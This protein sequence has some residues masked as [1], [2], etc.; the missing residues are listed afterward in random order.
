MDDDDG[1][2]WV[3]VDEFYSYVK[4]HHKAND[5]IKEI[6]RNIIVREISG[7][8]DS[9][10]NEG[11]GTRFIKFSSVLRYLFSHYDDLEICKALCKDAEKTILGKDGAFSKTTYELYK[12]I[13][14]SPAL[15][16][17]LY[18]I[19]FNDL[20]VDELNILSLEKDYKKDYND[21]QWKKIVLFEWHFN[22]QFNMQENCYS[23]MTYEE[24]MKKKWLYFDECVALKTLSRS[25]L[26]ASQQTIK[27]R[28]LRKAAADENESVELTASMQHRPNIIDT[29]IINELTAIFPGLVENVVTVSHLSTGHDNTVDVYIELATDECGEL[30][31]IAQFIKIKLENDHK[32]C[33]RNMIFLSCDSLSSYRRSGSFARFTLGDDFYAGKLADFVVH[34]L[35][36]PKDPECEINAESG[37]RCSSCYN[38]SLPK[39]LSF[40]DFDIVTEWFIDVPLQ[41][42]IML[43]SFINRAS[44]QASQKYDSQSFLKGKLQRLYTTYDTLLNTYSKNHIGLMQQ[45]NTE[46]LLMNYRSVNTV[47][48]VTSSSGASLSLTSADQSLRQKADEDLR[49]YETYVK[50]YPLVYTTLAGEEIEKQINLQECHLVVALDNLVRLRYNND[51]NPG[52]CRSKQLCTLPIT[53]QGLPKDSKVTESWHDEKICDGTP[54]CKCKVRLVLKKVDIDSTLFDLNEEEQKT[55]NQFEQLCTWGYRDLWNMLTAGKFKRKYIM[56]GSLKSNAQ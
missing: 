13:V 23:T 25:F 38:A 20:N 42:Q 43:E 22:K 11:N 52:E 46:E 7:H 6:R 4:S 47:F 12:A 48:S 31:L 55:S 27:V 2:K 40:I 39:P 19:L 49:H 44:L 21:D 1:T 26:D 45:A 15:N 54:R 36:V 50:R 17:D 10:K 8:K 30:N 34:F 56:K 41:V 32:L 3:D 5:K 29:Q 24:K 14:C 33:C 28:A 9:I 18:P 53:L 37:V 51:P 16:S 35:S